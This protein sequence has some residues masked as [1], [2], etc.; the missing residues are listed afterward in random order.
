MSLASLARPRRRMVFPF[1]TV[2]SPCLWF[3]Y[4]DATVTASGRSAANVFP[5]AIAFAAGAVILSYVI[6]TAIAAIAATEEQPLPRWKRWLFAPS[7][8]VIGLFASVALAFDIYIVA[9]TVPRWFDVV[10]VPVGVVVGWPLMLLVVGSIAVVNAFG[11][12]FAVIEFV[13]VAV[14]VALS[15]AW[16][17]LLFGWLTD[18]VG[19]FVGTAVSTDE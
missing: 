13:A 1:A 2:L 3:I 8:Q 16:L 11:Q 17:F 14:G 18:A 7:N 10:A 9:G 6:A 4:R 5:Q 19:R 12:Q 15:V